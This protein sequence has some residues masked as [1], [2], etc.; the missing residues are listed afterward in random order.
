[1]GRAHIGSG[2]TKCICS[3]CEIMSQCKYRPLNIKLRS[4]MVMWSQA[5]HDLLPEP[6]LISTCY[7]GQPRPA[8]PQERDFAVKTP[9]V[10]AGCLQYKHSQGS[11]REV[12][13]LWEQSGATRTG[14]PGIGVGD[15]LGWGGLRGFEAESVREALWET[16]SMVALLGLIAN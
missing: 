7:N 15:S 16:C 13:W 3:A 9:A 14:K 5:V 11:Q 1:M 10:S 6:P 8:L 12:E 4:S 2:N